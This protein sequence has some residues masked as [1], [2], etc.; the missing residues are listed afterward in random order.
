MASGMASSPIASSL[1]ST[2]TVLAMYP[3]ALHNAAAGGESKMIARIYR[4]TAVLLVAFAA[5]AADQSQAQNYPSRPLRIL[6][7]FPPGG[8]PDVLAR[9]VGDKLGTSLGQR[10]V[11]ENKPG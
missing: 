3:P 1:V 4:L 11:A 6:I 5:A 8:A 10:V 7:P 2:R 9:L